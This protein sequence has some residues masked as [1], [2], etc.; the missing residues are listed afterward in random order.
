MKS[1]FSFSLI[2]IIGISF[3][4]YLWMMQSETR[5]MYTFLT[6]PYVYIINFLIVFVSHFIA[7][8]V[9]DK[10][11]FYNLGATFQKI[12]LDFI[13]LNAVMLGTVGTTF[14]ITTFLF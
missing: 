9:L 3:G 7:W 4:L 2:S 6:A 8:I 1:F 10:A 13:I 12:I 11:T 5:P 14:L